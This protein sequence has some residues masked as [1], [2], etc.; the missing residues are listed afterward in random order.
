MKRRKPMSIEE[1]I[2]NGAS[3][4][5]INAAMQEI[6]LEK[7]REDKARAKAEQEKM[8]RELAEKEQAE[9]RA[10]EEARREMLKREARAYVINGLLAYCEAFD[11]LDGEEPTEQDIET[12]ETCLMQ[13]ESYLPLAKEIAKLQ[14]EQKDKFGEGFDLGLLGGLFGGGL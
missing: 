1:M 12:A 6:Y 4:E 10:E 5:E 8:I 14:A 9:A 11:L 2:K 3:P 13:I 7:E